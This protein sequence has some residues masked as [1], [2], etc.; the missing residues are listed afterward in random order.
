MPPSPKAKYFVALLF[1][2]QAEDGIRDPLVTGVQTCAL[3]IC[4]CLVRGEGSTAVDGVSTSYPSS[5]KGSMRWSSWGRRASARAAAPAAAG[6]G[7]SGRPP[8][9]LG[10]WAGTASGDVGAAG[11]QHAPGAVGAGGDPDPAGPGDLGVR[12]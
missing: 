3:P 4:P 2:F 11:H 12:H 5:H 1:F 7:G 10:G 6:W 9:A 8:A